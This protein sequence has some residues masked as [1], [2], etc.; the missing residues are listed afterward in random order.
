MCK[1]TLYEIYDIRYGLKLTRNQIAAK[2]R[3]DQ[4]IK[5]EA[6]APPIKVTG[7]H[8]PPIKPKIDIRTQPKGRLLP[9][10]TR[11]RK[12]RRL[13][14]VIHQEISDALQHVDYILSMSDILDDLLS[15]NFDKL[16]PNDP[17]VIGVPEKAPEDAKTEEE[18]S[19][20]SE[21]EEELEEE[22]EAKASPEAKDEA[23][24]SPA[25][26]VGQDVSKTE[27]NAPK[28]EA[29][30]EH[31]EEKEKHGSYK[32]EKPYDP[33][34][35][36]EINEKNLIPKTVA[37]KNHE[38]LFHV[39]VGKALPDTMRNKPNKGNPE[40]MG[41]ES[42]TPPPKRPNKRVIIRMRPYS[43]DPLDA[44]KITETHEHNLKVLHDALERPEFYRKASGFFNEVRAAFAE[45][46]IPF[47]LNSL[48]ELIAGYGMI[49]STE[50][51]LRRESKYQW[52]PTKTNM[53]PIVPPVP[54]LQD[55]HA[56]R[57]GAEHRPDY[58]HKRPKIPK[59]TPGT[60]SYTHLT[61]P[62]IYSV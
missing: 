47:T 26:T 58:T 21:D 25:E 44:E 54:T 19:E 9:P 60:V 39:I 14:R 7:K 62:T 10:N 31:K 52:F 20:Q 59:F 45:A 61:L 11:P 18:E 57:V 24:A 5:D 8:V 37:D 12:A 55:Q 49:D 48:N 34:D 32:K 53:V 1:A 33:N 27:E 41:E 15:G 23:E 56:E 51:S 22:K 29:K 16:D 28:G 38:H 4:D 50:N 2:L 13:K 6:G 30:E 35:K 42:K 36:Y 3:E 17:N 40:D 43:L 46:D